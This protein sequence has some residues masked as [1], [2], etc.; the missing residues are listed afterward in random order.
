MGIDTCWSTEN[1]DRM[2][3]NKSVCEGCF[4]F[5]W[6]SAALGV[7]D[8]LDAIATRSNEPRSVPYQ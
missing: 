7:V 1:Q 2:E 5:E 8:L 6:Q 3:N 4:E